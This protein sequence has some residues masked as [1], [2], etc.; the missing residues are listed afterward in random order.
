LGGNAILLAML[1]LLLVVV[2]FLP[3]QVS[4]YDTE[5]TINRVVWTALI[6]AG[7]LRTAGR[8]Y[9]LWA[10]L[11]IAIPSLLSRWIDVFGLADAGP[12][13]IALFFALI[14]G[15]ILTDIF[16]QHRIG[17]DHI[18]GGIN[19]YL[20]LGVLFTRLHVAV[21]MNDGKAY[22]LGDMPLRVAA[23]SM[24]QHVEDMMQYFSFTTL[25]TLGYGDIRPMSEIARMLSTVEAVSGQ[26]FLAILIARLVSVYV[27]HRSSASDATDS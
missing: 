15:H 26:L 19:V 13:I 1:I 6:I 2:P 27:S 5:G 7:I 8:R 10:A 9:F 23:Q 14:A 24:G 3:A 11:V 20:L 16:S 25:T 21:E 12:L 22:L 17:L 18:L 4:G